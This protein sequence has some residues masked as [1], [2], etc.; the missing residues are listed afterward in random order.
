MIP[1]YTKHGALRKHQLK[2]HAISL[3]NDRSC[4]ASCA[5]I[6]VTLKLHGRGHDGIN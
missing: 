5:M 2:D 6:G 1:R 4:A 3:R